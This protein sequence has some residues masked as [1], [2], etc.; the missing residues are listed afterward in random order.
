M[1]FTYFSDLKERLRRPGGPPFTFRVANLIVAILMIVSAIVFFTWSDFGRIMVGVYEIVFG[2]WMIMFELAELAWLT[3]QVQ[4]MFTWRGRGLFYVFI[5]CLTLGHKTFGWVVGAIIIAVG[6]VYIV[7]SFTSK[8]NESYGID[9]AGG[10]YPST[11]NIMYNT[12]P[13]YSQKND[14]Y[15]SVVSVHHGAAQPYYDTQK[16]PELT[17]TQYVSPTYHPNEPSNDQYPQQQYSHN[18]IGP[19]AQARRTDHLHSPI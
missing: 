4:F 1:A 16:Q 6:V 8:R 13:I 17:T 18:S 19:N 10:G 15:G 2:I 12:N 7:L 3:P 5:G 14:M 9:A 11:S